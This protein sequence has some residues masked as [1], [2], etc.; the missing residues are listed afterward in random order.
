M[1]A[2]DLTSFAAALK[3]LYSDRK[4][5]DLTYKN[6]PFLAMVSKDTNFVGDS[7]KHP[8]KFGN[9]KGR[10]ATFTTAQTNKA[11]SNYAAFTVTRVRD[12]GLASIDNETLEASKTDKGAFMRAAQAEIDSAFAGLGR[13]LASAIYRSGTGSIGVVG[14]VSTTSL[15][16]ASVGDVTN[17]EVGMKLQASA[18]DGSALVNSGAAATITAINRETGVL[19]AGVD[20]T[21]T[22][23]ALTAGYFLYAE[24]DA[25]SAASA[26]TK[27]SGLQAW[28]PVSAPS[29]TLFFGVDRSVDTT[30]LGGVRY[31]ASAL[32]IEEGLVNAVSRVTTEGGKPDAIFINP[33]KMRDLI[34]SLGSKV[35]YTSHKVGEI[36]FESVKLMT[37]NGPVSVFSDLNCPQA[38]AFVLQMDTW[39]LKSLGKAPRLLDS[40][41]NKMLRD[42]SADSVEVRCGYYGNLVCDAPGYNAIVTLS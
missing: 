31:D 35:Q 2:L 25:Q 5:H 27:I 33:I 29:A 42:G 16:L 39:Q 40:D 18:T 7:V 36:G 32:S 37:D 24:G 3:T 38:Y 1:A 9:I 8:L 21:T 13:S 23:A 11:A 30:R 26:R 10:S 6:A 41:G 14:A 4:I 15:T 28:L 34:N 17:F 19:T 12:Y 22:I 20:W